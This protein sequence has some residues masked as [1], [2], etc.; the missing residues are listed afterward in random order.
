MAKSLRVERL[1]KELSDYTNDINKV[2]DYLT[3]NNE[4]PIAMRVLDILGYTSDGIPQI[5]EN[6]KRIEK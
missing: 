5:L 1:E 4:D 3:K 2:V 6:I